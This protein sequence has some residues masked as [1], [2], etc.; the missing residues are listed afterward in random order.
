M[1]LL[2]IE[3]SAAELQKFS[4]K[5]L[6]TKA[7]S[8]RNKSRH[9]RKLCVLFYLPGTSHDTKETLRSLLKFAFPTLLFEGIPSFFIIAVITL[10]WLK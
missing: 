9:E 2:L 4:S 1:N 7:K 10:S 6:L 5:S 8:T 3:G